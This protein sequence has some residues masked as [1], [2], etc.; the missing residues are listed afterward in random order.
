[1][2]KM[3][4]VF[5]IVI[6]VLVNSVAC[7]GMFILIFLVLKFNPRSNAVRYFDAYA[8]M[9]SAWRGGVDDEIEI[10]RLL[11]FFRSRVILIC[12]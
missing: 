10:R 9:A 7:N 11:I 5:V 6:S 12:Y 8:H 3:R 2:L 1:M 4:F